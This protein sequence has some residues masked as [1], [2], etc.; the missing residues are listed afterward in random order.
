MFK[1]QLDMCQIFGIS[2]KN[3]Y[4]RL[5][6]THELFERLI[7]TYSIF[8]SIWDFVLPFRFQVRDSDVG[9][10]PIKFRQTGQLPLS[11]PKTASFGK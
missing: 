3:S 9:N 8:P 2:R 11:S 1:A 4:S 5:N 7:Y 6:I 10:A